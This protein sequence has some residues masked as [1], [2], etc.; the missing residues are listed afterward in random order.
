LRVAGGLVRTRPGQRLAVMDIA[1]AQWR[2][3]KLGKL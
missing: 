1:A 3:G 2:F